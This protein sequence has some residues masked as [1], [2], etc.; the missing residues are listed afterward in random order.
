MISKDLMCG[1]RLEMKALGVYVPSSEVKKS[2]IE[3]KPPADK[4]MEAEE[5]QELG[6]RRAEDAPAS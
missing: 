5:T 4:I 1:L 2:G 6:T 3:S